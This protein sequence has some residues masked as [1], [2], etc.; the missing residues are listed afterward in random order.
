MKK[1]VCLLFAKFYLISFVIGQPKNIKHIIFIGC[2]GM[3]AYAIDKPGNTTLK[4]MMKKGAYS[5]KAQSCL[6]SSSAINWASHFMGAGP[7]QHGYTKW[8]SKKP[9]NTSSYLN[10]FGMFPTIF[11][12]LKKQEPSTVTAAVYEWKGISYLI[13]KQSLDKAIDCTGDV[14]TTKQA[15]NIIEQTKPNLLFI[16]LNGPD[17]AGHEIGFNSQEFYTKVKNVDDYI[18]AI[19]S[20]TKKAGIFNQTLFLVSADHGG[21]NKDHGGDSPVERQVPWIWYGKPL[22]KT[23]EIK[24]NI[25]VYDT[26][27]TIAWLLGIKAEKA[28]IGKP[29]KHPF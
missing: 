21:K 2:D 8:N 17:S 15:V 29:V 6:P 13:E 27:P 3:G 7:E 9:E 14:E 5:L 1:N 12:A 10:E 28:W 19:I 24:K 20:A 4:M 18:S 25:M 11:Y 16:H 26:A 22:K 23:G